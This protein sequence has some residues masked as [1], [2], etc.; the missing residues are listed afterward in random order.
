[1]YLIKISVSD[2]TCHCE[3]SN[4]G[5]AKNSILCGSEKK[6]MKIDTC[7]PDEWCAGPQTLDEGINVTDY[8][9]LCQKGKV[10]LLFK[11]LYQAMWI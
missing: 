10:L 9:N 2:L 3:K 11:H 6:L 4:G 7:E 8:R 1:M 5:R